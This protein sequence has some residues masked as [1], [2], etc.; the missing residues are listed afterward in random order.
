MDILLTAKRDLAATRRFLVLT[1]NLHDT[2]E[3][4][5][6]AVWQFDL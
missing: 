3:K 6:F 1:I 4:I 2:P 5:T